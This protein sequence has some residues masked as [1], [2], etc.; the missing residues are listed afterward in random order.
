MAKLEA[1]GKVM[2]YNLIEALKDEL[3]ALKTWKRAKGLPEDVSE[4]IDISISKIRATIKGV[5]F[6][7]KAL[8]EA[9]RTRYQSDEVKIDDVAATS[10][11]D[12]DGGTWV[13][14]W[15]WILDEED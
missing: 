2:E 15:V 4:G 11:A 7:D 6:A 8:I 14:A 10:R 9:A 5:V 1:E 3:A 12:E 13:Q